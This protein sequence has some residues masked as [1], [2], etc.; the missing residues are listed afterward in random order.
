MGATA[1]RVLRRLSTDPALVVVVVGHQLL[2]LLD[3]PGVVSVSAAGGPSVG[4]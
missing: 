3:E 1:E 2:P 4:R